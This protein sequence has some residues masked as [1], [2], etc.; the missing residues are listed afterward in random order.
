MLK[1]CNNHNDLNYC[2]YG[3]RGISVCNTWAKFEP[4]SEWAINNGYE[5]SLTLDRINNDEGY[6]RGNIR[7]ISWRAN[8]LKGEATKAELIALGLDAQKF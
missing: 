4:F 7:I 3:G 5:E 8:H 6:I 1:R 2:Y